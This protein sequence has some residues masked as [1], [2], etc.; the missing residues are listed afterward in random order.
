MVGMVLALVPVFLFGSLAVLIRKDIAFSNSQLGL[1]MSSYFLS[2]TLS[3][4]AGGKIA[5][6]IG[7]RHGMLAGAMLN[8]SALL[9]IGILSVASWHVVGFLLLAG[10]GGGIGVPASNLVLARFVPVARQGIA[11]GFK[12]S[13][14]PLAT[15]VSGLAV[16][17]LGLTFGWRWAFIG[18]AFVLGPALAFSVRRTIPLQDRRAAVPTG[19]APLRPMVLLAVTA[20]L[21]G[22]AATA[23]VGFYVESAVGRGFD[24]GTAGFLLGGGSLFGIAARVLWGWLA[25]RRTRGH[26]VFLSVLFAVGSIGFALLGIVETVPLLAAVTLLV[27]VAGWSWSGLVFM[28]ATRG[29]PGSPAAATGITSAGG[30]VGG[31][32]GPFVFGSVVEAS[33][34]TVGWLVVAAWMLGAAVLARVTLRIWRRSIATRSAEAAAPS[35]DR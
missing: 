30:G 21:A 10:L 31:L 2:Y 34:Y 17:L 32:I 27:F 8:T 6:R 35:A 24:A 7:P 4:V 5:D 29:S 19:K 14:A 22:A 16:P 12:Q 20:G 18:V 9:G 11:F 1:T 15:V 23:A 25:D 28:V 33:S 26:L 3:A 13:A